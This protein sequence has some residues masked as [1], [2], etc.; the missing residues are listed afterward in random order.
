MK[1]MRTDIR[2]RE[3]EPATTAFAYRQVA[4]VLLRYGRRMQRLVF[5]VW[6]DPEDLPVLRRAVGAI[7]AATDLFDIVP[8][9]RRDPSRRISWQ[10][11]PRPA[12][13]MLV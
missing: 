9:D 6:L 10:R 11:S 7:L 8:I 12:A 2:V 3:V 5:E 13:V 1:E 4:R